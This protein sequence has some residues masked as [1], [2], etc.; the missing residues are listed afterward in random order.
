MNYKDLREFVSFLEERGQLHRVRAPVSCELEMTEI[1]DRM[2]KSGGPALLFE[3]VV[4]YDTPVLMNIFCSDQR[5]AWALGVDSVDELVARLE[6]MLQLAQGPPEGLINKL[7]TPGAANP[8][9][10]IPA[11][12]GEPGSLPGSGDTGA[13]C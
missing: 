6:G 12:D 11:Q 13:G 5:M 3:D 8:G 10:K 7:R 2:V 9:R 4:G 1:A